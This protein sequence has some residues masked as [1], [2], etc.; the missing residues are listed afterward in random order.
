MQATRSDVFALK[1]SGLEPFLY[2]SIGTE[3]NGSS[4]TILSMLARLGKDPWAEATIWAALPKANVIDALAQCIVQMPL[5]PSALAGTQERAGHLVQLL[6]DGPQVAQQAPSAE[7][8]SVAL[9][10][11]PLT[12]LYLAFAVWMVVNATLISQPPSN[13]VAPADQSLAIPGAD[14]PVARPL[15]KQAAK[16]ASHIP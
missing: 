10:R 5:T 16:G 15:P 11:G 1:N 6:P 3:I 4:L 12:I 8:A 2:E 14:A 13:V 9:K 7:A